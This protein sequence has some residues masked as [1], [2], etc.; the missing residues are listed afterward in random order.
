MK[1]RN[2]YQILLNMLITVYYL[3]IF[4]S[5]FQEKSALTDDLASIYGLG[6]ISDSYLSFVHSYL[7]SRTMAAR[8]VSGFVTATL[9]FLA[10]NNESIYFYGLLFFPLAL[11]GIYWVSRKI[12]SKELASLITL[13]YSCSIIGTSIQFSSMMLNSNLATIFYIIS[14]YFVYV[15]NNTVLSALFFIVSVLSYEIFLPL[16]LLHLFIV[17]D[18][19]ERIILAILTLG[20][21]F[22]F[23]KVI[24]PY[25][26][27]HSYQRDE[28]TKVFEIKRVLFVITLCFKMFLY[29]FFVGIYKGILHLRK[30]NVLGLVISVIIPLTVYKVFKNYD[31]RNK[32][33]DF[34]KLSAI[35]FVSIV[36]GL[37]I[38]LF[39][40]YIPTLFG[41]ENRNLGAIRLF[42]TLFMISGVIYL[43]IQ[44][45]LQQKIISIFLSL[46]VFLF[47]ITNISVKD[48][49]IYASRFN[50]E[51]FGKLNTALK[52]NKIEHGVICLEYGVFDE[53][54]SNPDLTLREPIFYKAWESPELCKMNGID[55]LKIRVDNINDQKDCRIKFLYKNGRM[56]LTQ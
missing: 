50:N 35:S 26:F 12:V 9:C 37:S 33:R 22:L 48:S 4:V 6:T 45:K 42:Y 53:L 11:I 47:I 8:P 14:I 31:F 18:N 54:K 43:S 3:Y 52:E 10:R 29:D 38:Y 13:L 17:K 15:R 27:E 2:N 7:D 39:S 44:L 46:I 41:F 24:Q 28:V 34:K 40:S 20:V 56:I 36:L 55:P 21:I 23:R 1:E 49:W 25:I 51:L 32:V 16:I 5:I 19:K 30:M